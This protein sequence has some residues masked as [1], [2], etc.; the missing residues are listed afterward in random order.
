MHSVTEHA[1]GSGKTGGYEATHL[2]SACRT[3]NYEH[4]RL[5]GPDGSKRVVQTKNQ[6]AVGFG[7]VRL[8]GHADADAV[9]F[10]LGLVALQ[11]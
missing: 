2:G 8:P 4:T 5:L 6:G 7:D 10:W 3:K 9:P 1:T 11:P